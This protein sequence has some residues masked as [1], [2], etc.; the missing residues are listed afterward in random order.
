MSCRQGIFIAMKKVLVLCIILFAFVSCAPQETVQ[1]PVVTIVPPPALPPPVKKYRETLACTERTDEVFN[2]TGIEVLPFLRIFFFDMDGDGTEE[3]VAGSKDGTLRLYRRQSQDSRMTWRLVD[4]YFDGIRAGAFSAPA[5]GDLDQDGRPEVVVGTGGFSAESG[6]VL[7]YRNVGSV[8]APVWQVVALPVIDV[9]DDAAPAL[10]DADADGRPDLVIGN[11]TGQLFFYRNV[12]RGREIAFR[13]DSGFF[14]GVSVGMYGMPAATVSGGRVIIIAGNSMGNLFL[15]E[16]G[17]RGEAGWS[18]TKLDV[19][20]SH[21]A[22]PAF[23]R[24]P[25]AQQSDLVVA[26]GNGQIHYLVTAKPNF[27]DWSERA[28][29]F[30]DRLLPGPACATTMTDL[31]GRSCLVTGNI[32]GELKL[33]EYRQFDKVLPWRERAEYFRGV[34]LSGFARGTFA[35][36]QGRTLLITGQ[37]DGFVRAFL[38]TG[39]ADRPAWKEQKDFFRGIPK[40]LHASPTVFDLD[41]DGVWELIVGDVDGRVRAY[42]R[43]GGPDSKPAW[44]ETPVIFS[45][46]KVGRYAAPGIVRDGDTVYLFVGGQDGTISLYTS[47]AGAPLAFRKDDLFGT[48]HV[49]NHGSP[50]AYLHN[51]N[52]E[53]AVGDYDGNLRN[54]ACTRE[55]IELH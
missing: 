39:S 27:R 38:N 45:A 7:V 28:T 53:L 6:R 11:S 1:P 5:V 52:V 35:E 2:R 8:Q 32:N 15:F 34:K 9:G 36:W 19:S 43:E 12:S 14:R 46:I 26:D 49:N 13:R 29:F 18:K 42:R 54:F 55:R 22:A 41:G 40:I 44:R 24:N 10:A 23:I 4:H 3:L 37:Q 30:S 20:F 21:F 16:R 51:G 50:A 31:E 48:I 33:Y 25:G 47:P 17:Q